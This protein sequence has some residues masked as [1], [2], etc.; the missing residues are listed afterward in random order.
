MGEKS[1]VCMCMRLL[2][3]DDDDN[4]GNNNNRDNNDAPSD[5]YEPEET[6]ERFEDGPAPT[7]SSV[8]KR[9]I[10]NSK[11]ASL[12]SVPSGPCP[13]AEDVTGFLDGICWTADGSIGS[14]VKSQV[15]TVPSGSPVGG[16]FGRALPKEAAAIPQL[17]L[18]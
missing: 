18:H 12:V 4:R 6:L 7:S 11:H 16:V 9:A 2:Y 5:K 10:I 13:T 3:S 8:A 17:R 1:F 14:S 15:E